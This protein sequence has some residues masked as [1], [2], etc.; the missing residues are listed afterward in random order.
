MRASSFRAL[1][2]GN[3]GFAPLKPAFRL[4]EEICDSDK[5]TDACDDKESGFDFSDQRLYSL[6]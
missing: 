5:D 2:N 1:I 3:M 6:S 4:S